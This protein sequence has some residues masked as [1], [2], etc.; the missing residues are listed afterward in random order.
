MRLGHDARDGATS[1]TTADEN[2]Q[3]TARF[4][5]HVIDSGGALGLAQQGIT[6]QPNSV[7][8]HYCQPEQR[9]RRLFERPDHRVD[10]P[11]L[12]AGT[13]L[14]RHRYAAGYERD[15]AG[16]GRAGDIVY[17]VSILRGRKSVTNPI[18]A[19]DT[20]RVDARFRQSDDER[21]ETE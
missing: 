11:A 10:A 6:Q 15:P 5:T 21:F 2:E 8:R 12:A 9:V 19:S 14:P 20:N 4:A 3:S 13:R 18:V 7:E 16:R 1:R 17:S